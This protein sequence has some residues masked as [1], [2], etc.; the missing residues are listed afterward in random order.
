M[1]KEKYL[2]IRG[3]RFPVGLLTFLNYL[4]LEVFTKFQIEVGI[5]IIFPTG[6]PISL[7][8]SFITSIQNSTQLHLTRCLQISRYMEKIAD[9]SKN[10]AQDVVFMVEGESIRHQ[11]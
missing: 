6:F 9:L 3:V 7:L 11:K 8:P 5:F 2:P 4:Y 10:F 1:V